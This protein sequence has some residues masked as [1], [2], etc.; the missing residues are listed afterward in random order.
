M[1][2]RLAGVELGGTKCIA[3]LGSGPDRIEAQVEVPTT[4]PDETLGRLRDILNDWHRSSG[5][6][7]LGLASF[8]PLDIA[9]G[10]VAATAKPGWS[11]ASVRDQL[12]A[13]FDLPHALD[14]DVTGAALA[15]GAWGCAQ[16]LGS[17]CYV[18]VGTG[19]GAGIIVNGKPIAGLGHA[20]AGHI[21]VAR[22]PGDSW[23]GNCP[24]HGDCVEGLASGSA[25]VARIGGSAVHL[26]DDDPIWDFVADALA[27]ML[28]AL[29]L[30]ATPERVILGGGV[31]NARPLLIARVRDRLGISLAGYSGPLAAPDARETFVRP[32]AL[33]AHVGPLGAL[34][35][36]RSALGRGADVP[37]PVSAGVMAR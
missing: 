26:G 23:P 17:Y 28:H 13:G 9:A 6:E 32:S 19:V 36:A 22:V 37:P 7:A 34:A 30:I 33:G 3:I 35:L 18:T 2:K 12:A 29:A 14:T 15:E 5:F 16:G 20:E 25:I 21:R 4:S 24:F 1:G 8:G 11:G 31:I 10:T 27:Q